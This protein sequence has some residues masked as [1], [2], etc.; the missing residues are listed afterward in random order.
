ME[1]YVSHEPGTGR[2]KVVQI[3]GISDIE[4]E[5]IELSAVLSP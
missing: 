2:A 5:V 4:T 3:R 1:K